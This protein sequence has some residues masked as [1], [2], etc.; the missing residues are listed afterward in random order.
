MPAQP[1]EKP[2]SWAEPAA[3]SESALAPALSAIEEAGVE[4]L[5]KVRELAVGAL[6]GVLGQ[7]VANALP[8][9]LKDEASK[10]VKDLTT[11]LGG[12]VIDVG[13]MLEGLQGNGKEESGSGE[14]GFL[15]NDRFAQRASGREF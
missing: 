1:V 7:M 11:K 2:S 9:V 8:P 15:A 6:M 5:T 3:K 14:R 4:A 10:L 13:G 12:K